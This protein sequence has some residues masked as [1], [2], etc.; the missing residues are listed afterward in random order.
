MAVAGSPIYTTYDETITG[1]AV[2]RAFGG[3]TKF[4]RDM[5]CRVDTVRQDHNQRPTYIDHR[6]VS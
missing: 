4:L 5:L 3:S 2:I 1:V 6:F